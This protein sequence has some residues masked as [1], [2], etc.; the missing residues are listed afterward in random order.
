MHIDEDISASILGRNIF[1]EF[2]GTGGLRIMSATESSLPPTSLSA[3]DSISGD[4]AGKG[5]PEVHNLVFEEINASL[6]GEL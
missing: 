4:E 3:T 1:E 6:N 2:L 5:P